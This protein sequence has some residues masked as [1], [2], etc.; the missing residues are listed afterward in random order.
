L[1]QGNAASKFQLEQAALA[2]LR[3]RVLSSTDRQHPAGCQ[4][5][6]IAGSGT[7]A[8]E[9]A[10]IAEAKHLVGHLSRAVR[11]FVLSCKRRIFVREKE[12]LL[13]TEGGCSDERR[14]WCVG[15]LT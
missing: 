4:D 5:G 14:Q 7:K 9:I 8:Q 2:L 6:E 15:F 11:D 3:Q 10:S 1:L 13:H 12:F